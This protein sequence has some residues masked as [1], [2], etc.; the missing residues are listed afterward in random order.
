MLAA[1]LKRTWRVVAVVVA[2]AVACASVPDPQPY[3]RLAADAL[4][5]EGPRGPL[6]QAESRRILDRLRAESGDSDVLGRH[7][8]SEAAV[9]SS[10]LV[11]DNKAAL[12]EDGPATFKAML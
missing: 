6:S 8:A 11:A 10:P 4:R 7:L 5:V 1:W 9:A 2:T 3:L 12:L